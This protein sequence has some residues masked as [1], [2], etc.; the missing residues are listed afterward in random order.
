MFKPCPDKQ[1]QDAYAL[2]KKTYA[3]LDVDADAAIKKALDMAISLHCW[4]ADDVVGFEVK[5]GATDTG[6]I[7][8]TGNYPGRARNGD[9]LRQDVEQALSL[10][11]GKQRLNIHAS[12]AETNGKP[13]DRDA[14][15]PKHFA[16]FMEWAKKNGIALDFN[17]TFFAHPKSGDGYTLSHRDP[18]IRKFWVRHAIACRRIAQEMAKA[19]GSPCV[20]NHWIPDGAKDQPAD[21]WGPRAR[22]VESLDEML[23]PKLG[24]DPKLCVDAVEGKLFGIGSEDYTVGSNEF[25][26]QYALRKGCVLCLDMGHFHPTET[27]ADKLSALMQFQPR[28][29]LH[30]S[31]GI[32]WDS[33]HVVIFNDDLRQVFNELV[34]GNALDRVFVALDYFD[35]SINRIGAYVVGARAT[36][37]A[38]LA[39]LLTPHS[40][41]KELE[42]TGRNAQKLALQEELRSLPLGA[43]WDELC[44]R[45][46]VPVGP[47]WIN[48]IEKYEKEV[49]SK[50]K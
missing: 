39:A 38:A 29:L 42:A 23:D 32:R 13:V 18:K 11:P 45:A 34:S 2:A 24:V 37:K 21:R 14:L 30:V 16:K 28:L 4:Q 6:G 25:Y 20:L 50:R 7:M 44:R 9:E 26:S 33:D 36:R 31:R 19:Q 1:I 47:A 15:E 12:Y 43:V 48:E 5:P 10:L 35:A 8:A 49:L 22:L 3:A 27:I 17:P 41:L 40:T 46:E